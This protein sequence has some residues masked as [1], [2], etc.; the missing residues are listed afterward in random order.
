MLSVLTT[1][2]S[3]TI[4]LS[5]ST[6]FYEVISSTDLHFCLYEC[7]EHKWKAIS[8]D[9]WKQYYYFSCGKGHTIKVPDCHFLLLLFWVVSNGKCGE[10]SDSSDDLIRNIPSTILILIHDLFWEEEQRTCWNFC[11]PSWS[12]LI[13]LLMIREVS[14]LFEFLYLRKCSQLVMVA[15]VLLHPL[16]IWVWYTHAFNVVTFLSWWHLCSKVQKWN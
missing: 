3:A 11:F 13:L 6:S 7:L 2:Q 12:L 5:S 10:Y 9:W 1:Q 4:W 15:I 16:K 14:G 8:Q